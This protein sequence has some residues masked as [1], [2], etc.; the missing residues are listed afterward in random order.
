MPFSASY[1]RTTRIVS[2]VVCL[3]LLAVVFAV[4]SLI[5]GCLSLLVLLLGFAYSPRG[6]VLEG[7]S[8]W[9]NR[10]A[11]RVRIALDDVR[12]ARRATPDDFRGC[13]RLWGSGGLFGYYG[14][15]STT[16][17]GKSTWYVTN[18]KNCVIVIGGGKTVLFSPDDPDS[19]LA[20]IRTATPIPEP[21][22]EPTLAPSRSFGSVLKIIAVAAAVAGVGA[23][24]LA[25]NYSPGVP[26]YTLTAETL[27]IHDRLY[28][29]TLAASSVDVSQ[30]RIVDVSSDPEWRLTARTNGFANS[31]YRSGWFRAANGQKVRLYLANSS[32]VVLLPPTG[33]GAPV[34]Y[35]AGDPE[36]FISEL[37]AAWSAAPGAPA[38]VN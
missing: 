23:A 29:V 10:A 17:L 20:T 7:R 34:L 14:L 13:V 30:I 15:F 9:V 28:P 2:A 36:K 38:Q 11:G 18:R 26:A 4:H 5:L 27:T 19:F 35:Q 8:I 33:G 21:R 6:Y 16:R 31:H 3:G 37:R 32:R 24:I 12:E 22:P 25:S 1:D